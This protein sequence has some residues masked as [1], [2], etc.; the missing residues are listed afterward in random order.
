MAD[1]KMT[2]LNPSGYQEVLQTSDQLIIDSDSVEFKSGTEV[3]FF[4]ATPAAQQTGTD[5]KPGP[6]LK[7]I[8]DTLN[9]FGLTDISFDDDIS[10]DLDELQDLLDNPVNITG[11]APIT[12]TAGADAPDQHSWTI[13][14]NTAS[15]SQL[16]A[17]QVGTGISVTDAGVISTDVDLGTNVSATENEITNSGGTN[18]TLVGA[19]SNDAGLLTSTLYDKLNNLGSAT[20]SQEGLIEIATKSEIITGT[21]NTRA[22]SPKGLSDVLDENGAVIGNAL[23][24]TDDGYTIDCGIYYTDP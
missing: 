22:V 3:G 6:L 20:D 14:I 17:V 15:T 5:L 16:G 19:N 12:A 2:V 10:G 23:V 11:T 18:A 13:A 7:A 9:T 8:A 1:R 4:D 24:K 21:D